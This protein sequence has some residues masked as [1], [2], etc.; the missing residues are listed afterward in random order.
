VPLIIIYKFVQ[1]IAACGASHK[2]YEKRFSTGT[3]IQFVS[4]SEAG[5]PAL[6]FCSVEFEFASLFPTKTHV[7]SSS[8]ARLHASFYY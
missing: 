7:V 5:A 3:L 2:I 4:F 1:F 8:F 6:F